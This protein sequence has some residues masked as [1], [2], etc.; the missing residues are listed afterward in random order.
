MATEVTRAQFLT[1]MGHDP[2]DLSVSSSTNDPVQ[3]VNRYHIMAFC[4]KLSL[5]DGLDEVYAVA[6][7]DFSTLVFADIP[8]TN[9]ADWNSPTVTWT[10]GGYRLPTEME[11]QWAAMGAMDAP[12]KAFAGSDG[13]NSIDDYVWYGDSSGPTHPVAGKL[14][15]ELGLYDMSGN[16]SEWCWDWYDSYPA[17]FLADY[18][19]P[20]PL[21]E[22]II[23]GG[24]KKN[25]AAFQTVAYRSFREP[26][27]PDKLFGFRVVRP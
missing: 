4:N 2:S 8:I 10:A 12:G 3:N 13:S 23:R 14:P 27:L 18:R 17:G 5:R 11:W 20:V 16:V 15:N 25:G 24:N 19:G 6:G 7:V 22:I 21:W 9:N 26:N 1:V